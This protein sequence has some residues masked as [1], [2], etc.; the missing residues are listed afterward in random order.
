M[1]VVQPTVQ[2]VTTNGVV[3]TPLAV[4]AA[5][6]QMACSP[7]DILQVIN[8]N[9]SPTVVTIATPSTA[10]G[11]PIDEK[12]KSVTNG[13]Q[14]FFLIPAGFPY[15]QADDKVLVSFSVVATVTYNLYRK[16]QQ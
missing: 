12:V 13:T 3:P 15:A 9:A 14:Q 7:G 8:G 5:T 4:P 6:D 16:A 10:A 2:E 11:N 1:A